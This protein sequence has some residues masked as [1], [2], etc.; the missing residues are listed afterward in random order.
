ML[1]GKKQVAV[2][3]I[4]LFT[5]FTFF[6]APGFVC[7]AQEV[8]SVR[9]AIN[10]ALENNLQVKQAQF[11]QSLA[12]QDLRQARANFYPT[13][14]G[15][16]G[17]SRS[18]GLLF[19][20][21]SGRLLNQSATTANVNLSSTAM[22]FQGMQRINQVKA[23]RYQLMADQSNVERV[24]NDLILSV[25]TTYLE[26]LTNQDLLTASEQQ[27]ALSNEQLAAMKVNFEVG[28]KTLAD[29]SQAQSQVATDELNVT[30]AQNAFD[31]AVL[32]LKQLMEMAPS[33]PIALQKPSLPDVDQLVLAYAPDEVFN[34][35]V[36]RYPDVKQ[37]T[38]N[39]LVA[40]RVVAIQKG[41]YYPTLSISGGIG[42]S[43]S[44]EA[45]D[46]ITQALLPFDE[47]LR[48]NTAQSVGLSLRIPIFNNLTTNINVR[49]ARISYMN[50]LTNEQLAKNNLN[51]VIHQ[52]VLDLRAAQKRYHSTEVAF[53]SAKDA[54]EVIRQ[55]FEVGLA[56]A[57]EQS[58]AQ[59]NM[60]RA[61]FDFIQ[62]RYDLIFRSK[63]IDFYL[64]NTIELE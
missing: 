49:K 58:T 15:S 64:G 28:N 30:T 9:E 4:K 2:F 61:E 34:T 63:V 19:D 60:N 10:R 45:R 6:A 14:N 46:F 59:T 52:A 39:T 50:A 55:R 29:L 21:T 38:L 35:A 62:A 44:S 36:A 16:S 5:F 32:N 56:N 11:Q 27:L 25:V 17:V 7:L 48:R 12:E 18:W 51:K 47:Q 24:K 20:Q 42:T 53:Q 37:A 8:I 41:A 1:T 57:V 23:N 13:L 31:L 54:F 3:I 22:L 26:A 43:Y 33:R 40:E